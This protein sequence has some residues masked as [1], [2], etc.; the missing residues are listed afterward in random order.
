MAVMINQWISIDMAGCCC[1][2]LQCKMSWFNFGIHIM[3]LSKPLLDRFT[4]ME[5]DKI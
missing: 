3:R 2:A 1:G 4:G 5:V